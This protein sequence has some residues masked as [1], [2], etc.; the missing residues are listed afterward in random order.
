MPLPELPATASDVFKYL[1]NEFGDEFL[2][3]KSAIA[4][5]KLAETKYEAYLFP[6]YFKTHPILGSFDE[7]QSEESLKTSNTL[8][9]FPENI[10]ILDQKYIY[11]TTLSLIV[12]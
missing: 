4:K 1:H 11:F 7:A 9:Y 3:E 6:E 12:I 8:R 10:K 5:R 2:I